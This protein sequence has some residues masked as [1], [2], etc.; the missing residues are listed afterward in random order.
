MHCTRPD[1]KHHRLAVPP[2][3]GRCGLLIR[4]EVDVLALPGRQSLAENRLDEPGGRWINLR[5]I[6]SQP[7]RFREGP[8]VFLAKVENFGR[9]W[10]VYLAFEDPDREL[11]FSAE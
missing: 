3:D 1:T 9:N 7:V 10:R 6:E 8:N 2:A 4:R 11:V 5:A